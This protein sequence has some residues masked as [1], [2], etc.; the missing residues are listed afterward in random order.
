MK[1]A[2]TQSSI[3]ACQ[4]GKD[5]VMPGL[6]AMVGAA[7]ALG[8]VTRMTVSLV[9]IMFELTGSLEFIV[10]TM[11]AVMFAKWVGDAIYKLVSGLWSASC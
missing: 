2:G 5:C 7:A 9:V 3:W 6:Y 4:I 1:G 8:G 11:V 10:P